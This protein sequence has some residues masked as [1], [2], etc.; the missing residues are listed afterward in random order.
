M[1]NIKEIYKK[2]LCCNCGT[3]EAVCPVK[4]ITLQIDKRGFYEP[5]IKSRL[6]IDCGKCYK[7]CP[8][9][10]YI[11]KG[12]D[13]THPSFYGFTN[14]SILRRK[15]TSGG[16]L[17][18]LVTYLVKNNLVSKAIVVKTK[19]TSLEPEVIITDNIKEIIN[20]ATSKYCPVPVNKV[21]SKIRSSKDT[22]VIVGLPCHIQ[23]LKNVLKLD[24]QLQTKIKFTISL[25]CNHTPSF[26]AT[27]Y[28]LANLNIKDWNK[29][30]YRG[31]G[32]PGCLHIISA[33]PIKVPFTQMWSSG[34]GQYFKPY[35]CLICNDPF[36]ELADATFGDAWFINA[37]E[38]NKGNSIMLVRSKV[39][40]K[41]INSMKKKKI[42]R[43]TKI[44]NR[45]FK[46]Y[47]SNMVNLRQTRLPTYL[48]TARLLGK[49]IPTGF[50]WKDTKLQIEAVKFFLRENLKEKLGRL[51]ILWHPLYLFKTRGK[52]LPVER[53]E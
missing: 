53:I 26:N 14:N 47:L 48:V 34:F 1:T 16:L 31:M 49:S 12:I 32:W 19:A 11:V 28:I 20:S 2:D 40:L 42:I 36:G 7:I 35:R 23:G 8:G 52:G 3:C 51:R 18:E 5:R 21:I 43:L 17:T 37:K 41:I 38:D 25:F 33:N 22:F 13:F 46:Q 50:V 10:E 24:K 4:A 45:D 15:A 29:I 30:Y 39:L 9:K 6:C 44:N 27:K